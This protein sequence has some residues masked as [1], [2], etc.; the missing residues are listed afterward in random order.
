METYNVTSRD[1]RHEPFQVEAQ[2]YEQAALIAAGH[3]Y[4]KAGR[5]VV[6]RITGLAGKSGRFHAYRHVAGEGDAYTSF[7]EPF[8]VW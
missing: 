8:H 4:P 7:G 5:L 3:L 1:E 6:H 2:S